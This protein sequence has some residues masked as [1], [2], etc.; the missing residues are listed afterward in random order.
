M[1]HFRFRAIDPEQVQ[2]LSKLLVDEL[3]ELM[4][5]PRE[6]FTIEYIP[7]RFFAEAEP[8]SAWPFV[9]ALY[10]DRGKALQGRV[11][12][13]VTSLVRQV[14]GD[15]KQDVTVVFTHLDPE[16]YYDNGVHY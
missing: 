2:M 14:T 13:V 11:A 3:Q 7:A 9:E 12:E 10:F 8:T 16:S 4:G 6:D 1:P 5:S 15:L